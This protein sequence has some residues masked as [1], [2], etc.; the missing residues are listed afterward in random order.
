M[1]SH[2]SSLRDLDLGC[3]RAATNGK[4]ECPRAKTPGSG[5]LIAINKP[6]KSTTHAKV[7]SEAFAV[8]DQY[9]E[10]PQHP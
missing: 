8:D 10:R 7:G 6:S 5:Q 4:N 2:F 9:V 1:A 3:A